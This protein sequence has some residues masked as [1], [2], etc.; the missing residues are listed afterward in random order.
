MVAAMAIAMCGASCAGV[1]NGLGVS[2]EARMI[3]DLERARRLVDA[4]LSPSPRAAERRVPSETMV[5][6]PLLAEL[7]VEIV[8]AQ[9]AAASDLS[10]KEKMETLRAH[11]ARGQWIAAALTTPQTPV[12]GEPRAQIAM[13]RDAL[14]RLRSELGNAGR[15]AP[16]V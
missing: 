10:T 9:N 2:K 3:R 16:A 11:I 4:A 7:R 15:L 1:M 13:D 6:Q 14:R 5:D 8:A 12:S